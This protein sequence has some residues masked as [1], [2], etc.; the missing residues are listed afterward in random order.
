MHT[1]CTGKDWKYLCCL[2]H[3]C[4]YAVNISHQLVETTGLSATFR[5]AKK[6]LLRVDKHTQSFTLISI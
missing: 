6:K 1:N 4:V 2:S 3:V 5:G